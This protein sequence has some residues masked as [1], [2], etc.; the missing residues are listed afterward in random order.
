MKQLDF[1]LVTTRGGDTGESFTYDGQKKVKFDIVFETV[2]DLDELN[3]FLGIVRNIVEKKQ[4][5]QIKAI[6]NGILHLSS[7]IATDPSSELYETFIK[8]SE[9]DIFRLEK[10]QKKLM[11]DAIIPQNFILPGEKKTGSEYIDIAR[12]V[13]RRS[14]RNIVKLIRENN[15]IDLFECQKYLNRLSDFLFTLARY[16]DS[17]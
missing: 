10:W 2:G 17:K 5:W 8:I 13:C 12:S 9:K 4:E 14:E 16:L 7:Q 6:Q 3:S 11:K 15:R 1:D